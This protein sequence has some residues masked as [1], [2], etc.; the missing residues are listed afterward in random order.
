MQLSN[1]STTE[2]QKLL[3][4][5]VCQNLLLM[6][7]SWH[8]WGKKVT[9]EEFFNTFGIIRIRIPPTKTACFIQWPQSGL[10]SDTTWIRKFNHHNWKSLLYQLL[11]ASF[12]LS[13]F[14]CLSLYYSSKASFLYSTFTIIPKSIH[15]F[16]VQGYLFHPTGAYILALRISGFLWAQPSKTPILTHCIIIGTKAGASVI[17]KN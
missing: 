17:C 16:R 15:N 5:H 14:S 13:C 12:L 6:G 8:I 3:Q 1:W 4:F 9:R 7:Q 2:N 10:S 11:N